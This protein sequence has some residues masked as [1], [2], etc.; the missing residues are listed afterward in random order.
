MIKSFLRFIRFLLIGVLWSYLFLIIAN[1][2]MYKLWNFSLFS[3]HS[4]NTVSYFWNSGGVIKTAPDYI[5]LSMLILLP[6]LWIVGW[7]MLNRVDYKNILLFP[8]NAYNRHIIKK[9]G[10]DSSRI[11]LK[12]LKSSQQMIEEIK[13][14]IALIKPEAPK[15][16]SSIRSQ[17]LKK[18]ETKIKKGE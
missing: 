15:E 7:L 3:A 9:Y 16:V 4:W 14:K 18:I 13:D 6:V 1:I 2:L 11:L 12:N 8:I 10:H 17:I 5:F